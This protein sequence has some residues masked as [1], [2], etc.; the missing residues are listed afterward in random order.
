MNFKKLLEELNKLSEDELVDDFEDVEVSDE[1]LDTPEEVDT[2]KE[3]DAKTKISRALDVLKDA[4]E[5]FK[6][7]TIEEL[8]LI[9]DADLTASF[10]QLDTITSDIQNIITGKTD[11]VESEAKPEELETVEDEETEDD[12]LEEVNFDDEATI[13]LFGDEEETED[14]E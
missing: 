14:E 1:H 8:D 7:A 9:S 3:L 2:T 4:I 5:D 11:T 10:E 13:D 12:D 6:S